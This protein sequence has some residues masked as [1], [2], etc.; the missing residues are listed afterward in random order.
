MTASVERLKNGAKMISDS[1]QSASGECLTA[2]LSLCNQITFRRATAKVGETHERSQLSL[3][4]DQHIFLKHMQL[5]EIGHLLRQHLP[6]SPDQFPGR[7][8]FAWKSI[9]ILLSYVTLHTQRRVLDERDVS[10]C[11]VSFEH[12]CLSQKNRSKS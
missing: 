11:F 6:R 4:P 9:N 3:A 2:L 8:L 12:V 7:S 5:A 10:V 1:I